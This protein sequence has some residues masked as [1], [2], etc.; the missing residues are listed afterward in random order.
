MEDKSETRTRTRR[1]AAPEAQPASGRA[2]AA[3]PMPAS[4]SGE[5]WWVKTQGDQV[6]ILS[7]KE[8]PDDKPE[9]GAHTIS[10][11]GPMALEESAR[12][13]AKRFEERLMRNSTPRPKGG[14]R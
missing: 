6:E 11:V 14:G 9:E 1:G 13:L 3:R 10:L 12:K 5:G 2:V 8:R 7:S 4:G